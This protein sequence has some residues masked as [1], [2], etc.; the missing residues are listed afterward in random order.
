MSAIPEVITAPSELVP[1]TS[2]TPE[3]ANGANDFLCLLLEQLTQGI[4]PTADSWL[5]LS[6]LGRDK[7]NNG[8]A[9]DWIRHDAR[10]AVVS[11]RSAPKRPC[12]R[13]PDESVGGETKEVITF[14]GITFAAVANSPSPAFML[15]SADTAEPLDSSQT[16]FSSASANEPAQPMNAEA[17][18]VPPLLPPLA[19]PETARFAPTHDQSGPLLPPPARAEGSI[20]TMPLAR[21][22]ITGAGY[23]EAEAA[24]QSENETIIP[25]IVPAPEPPAVNNDELILTAPVAENGQKAA[26]EVVEKMAPVQRPEIFDIVRREEQPAPRPELIA[27][28]ELVVVASEQWRPKPEKENPGQRL[29]AKDILLASAKTPSIDGDSVEDSGSTSK[30]PASPIFHVLE[31]RARPVRLLLKEEK[32]NLERELK[33]VDSAAIYKALEP[34]AEIIEPTGQFVIAGRQSERAA[35]VRSV[36]QRHVLGL[37]AVA[38]LHQIERAAHRA[39]KLSRV[40]VHLR[41]PDLGTINISVESR[42]GNLSA[43]LAASHPLVAAWLETN[44]GTLRSHL[45]EA[46]LQFGKVNC[47]LTSD[48]QERGWAGE[49]PQQQPWLPFEE[50]IVGASRSEQSVLTEQVRLADWRA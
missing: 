43:R 23:L 17:Q 44:V 32:I 19:S 39:V 29:Q 33:T 8:D 3:M 46:G 16:D 49:S 50:R 7:I 12:G 9:A 47:S 42:E 27:H 15:P 14:P 26:S 11:H 25:K 34:S 45:T 1:D 35:E 22:S 36:V 20:M 13:A 2:I 37:E 4:E 6:G 40:T 24:F 18:L 28:D 41:P 38:L 48:Q 30:R 21:A 10:P 5:S 31:E